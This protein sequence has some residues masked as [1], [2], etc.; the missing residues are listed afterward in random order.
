MKRLYVLVS[1]LLAVTLSTAGTGTISLGWNAPAPVGTLTATGYRVFIGTAPGAYGLPSIDTATTS[2]TIPNLDDCTTYYACIKAIGSNGVLSTK[3]GLSKG[4]TTVRE[5]FGWPK[6][7]AN[8]IA[9][10]VATPG[11]KV[12]LQLGGFN[13]KAPLAARLL[14]PGSNGWPVISCATS[15][16]TCNGVTVECEI[17][18]T[19][20]SGPRALQLDGESFGE[21]NGISIGSAVLIG[22]PTDVKRNDSLRP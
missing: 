1:M 5:Q 6:I 12:T 19:A 8:A 7:R 18:A 13:F 15:F 9:T 4:S 10:Q 2:V 14:D 22:E 17:P 16:A 11:A 21:V 20:P 3:C